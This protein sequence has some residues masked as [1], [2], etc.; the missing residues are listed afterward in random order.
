MVQ[1][2]PSAVERFV[3]RLDGNLRLFLLFGPDAGLVN[4]RANRIVKALGFDR[5]DPLSTVRLDA[6]QVAADPARLADEAYAVSMFG[7]GRLVRISGATRRN[8]AE[9]VKPVL[10]QPPEDGYLLLE[11]GDLK[12]GA[13]LRNLVEKSD[14]G[15]AIPC[16]A[17]GPGELAALIRDELS[18]AG[19]A[20]GRDDVTLLASLLGA[21]RRASRNELR[22]LALYCDGAKMVTSAEILAVVSD[23]SAIEIGDIIDCMAVGDVTGL[24]GCFER[25]VNG[26]TPPD[27]V[28]LFA[29]R[30]FQGLR[31]NRHL[32]KSG[33]KSPAAVVT[34]LRP[35]LHFRRRDAYVKALSIWTMPMIARALARLD[36]ALLECRANDALARSLAATA[37]LAL[38]IEAR[39]QDEH[40]RG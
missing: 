14:N 28:V 30:H 27:L 6:D 32:V 7:G 17:D 4:E 5:A 38:A 21:D 19:L 8:L 36:D 2:K 33:G 23:T 9:A 20:I 39:R 40:R 1:L 25:S 26:G 11:S 15:V 10:E 22:K 34:A 37:L 13:P 31:A 35:P 18:S 16:Y 3:D 24:A 29:L 12:R